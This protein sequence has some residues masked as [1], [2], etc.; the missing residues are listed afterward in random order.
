MAGASGLAGDRGPQRGGHLPVTRAIASIEPTSTASIRPACA[1]WGKKPASARTEPLSLPTA[2]TSRPSSPRRIRDPSEPKS[3]EIASASWGSSGVTRSCGTWSLPTPMPD[4]CESSGG[5]CRRNGPPAGSAAAGS[6]SRPSD[7]GS[8][9]KPILVESK[10]KALSGTPLPHP[11]S[12]SVARSLE[13]PDPP[14]HQPSPAGAALRRRVCP[15]MTA[16]AFA[17]GS[18]CDSPSRGE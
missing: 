13:E 6:C 7:L 14:P 5:G 11:V 15:V 16:S 10:W 17:C 18:A 1:G 9:L 2:A 4:L 3:R 12:A 8:C